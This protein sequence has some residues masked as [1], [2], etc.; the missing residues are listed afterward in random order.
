MGI[1]SDIRSWFGWGG[2]STAAGAP[3]ETPQTVPAPAQAQPP[4]TPVSPATPGPGGQPAAGTGGTAAPAALAG[5]VFTADFSSARQWVAGRS[6]AYPNMGPTNRGDHKLDYLVRQYCPGGVF[7]AVARAGDGLW[8][9]NLLTTEGSPDGF[10][11]RAGD[12]LRARVTLPTGAG[13]WPAIWT[14]RDGR[15]EVDV[16]E[17]HPDNP[18][19]LELSNHMGSGSY[20]YWRDQ[21][22]AVAPGA[23]IDLRVTLGARS[24]DWYVNGR[25]VYAD[26]RGV[27]VGWHAYLIVNMS[28]SDGTYHPRPSGPAGT[29]LSWVCHSLTVER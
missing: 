2:G 11:V 3:A 14:W 10:Q 8:N 24:V 26:G 17:Y 22:G 29:R 18:N 7:S 9:C 15:N 19:L 5:T 13:A 23:T 12:V 6:S 28:V 20:L 21:S 16:F 1:W 4:A 25:R 27:G